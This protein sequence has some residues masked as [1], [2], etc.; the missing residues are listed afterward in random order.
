MT[1]VRLRSSPVESG[2]NCLVSPLTDMEERNLSKSEETLVLFTDIEYSDRGFGL[3]LVPS[4]FDCFL[5]VEWVLAAHRARIKRT[6]TSF[7]G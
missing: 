6:T 2:E 1:I 4:T 7:I 3:V 5:T